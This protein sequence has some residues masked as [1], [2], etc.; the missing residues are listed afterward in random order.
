MCH[1]FDSKSKAESPTFTDQDSIIQQLDISAEKH[2]FNLKTEPNC[3]L[4]R[5]KAKSDHEKRHNCN[6]T[7]GIT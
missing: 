7:M 1:D 3:Y 6:H 2:S 5:P 4:K